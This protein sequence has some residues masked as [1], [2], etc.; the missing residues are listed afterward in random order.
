MTGGHAPAG[1]LGGL[2]AAAAERGG[3][4]PAVV[5]PD[6]ELTYAELDGWAGAVSRRLAAEG[7]RRGDRVVLWAGKS[8]RAVVA[9]QACLRVGAVYVP[10]DA[11]NPPGRVAA[12]AADCAASLVVAGP[13]V[14]ARGQPWPGRLLRLDTAWPRAPEP[15]APRVR[16][17]PGDLAYVL[18]T[19]GSTGRPKGVCLTHGNALAFV[20]W[21]ARCFGIA[22]TDRLANHAPFSFDLSVLDLYAAFRGGASVHLVPDGLARVPGRLVDFLHDERVTVW[23]S[24]PS[25]L[26]LM[27]RAGGLL[28]RERPPALRA[29]LFAGEVFPRA[30]LQALVG[31]WP[32]V[33]FFNLY[34]PT[35]TNVCT[36]H[37]VTR[38]DVDGPGPLPIGHACC[39]DRVRVLDPTGREVGPGEEGELVVEG[40]TVMRGYWG[41][42][43][44]RGPYRTGDRVRVLPGGDV[45]FLG[46][47]DDTLKVRGHRVAPA[48]VEAV[49][50]GH[51]RIAEVAVGTAGTSDQASLVAFVVPLPGARVSLLDVKR[52]CAG[53]LPPWL[54]VDAVEVV[55]A[56]PRDARGKLD[57]HALRRRAPGATAAQAV[58][59]SARGGPDG[60]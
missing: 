41:A 15:E 1:G 51:P 44:Q 11:A 43:P 25:A 24:V 50:A 56:L 30:W 49:L 14:A 6:G 26:V 7:V 8:A 2:V 34:G 37:E 5:A 16:G 3:S 31:R 32:A 13:E 42:P 55:D 46:R 12:I 39:G 53:S 27:A 45:A 21:A 59:A 18:Y 10:V 35:E 19:S 29:V 60:V 47:L 22:P 9:M 48:E 40:P 58:P 57:R 38:A 33:R 52:H 17:R 4:R 20:D 28:E 54:I 23:Y 36:Y